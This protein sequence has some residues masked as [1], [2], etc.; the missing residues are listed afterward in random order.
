VND[1][2]SP[3]PAPEPAAQVAPVAPVAHDT[4]TSNKLRRA[5]SRVTLVMLFAVVLY[6]G[7]AVFSGVRALGDRLAGF[8][9]WTFGAALLLAFGNYII[10]FGKWQYYLAVLDIR[11][12]PVGDSFLTFLSGFILSVTPGKLGEVFKSYVLYETHG[13]PAQRTAPIV[14]AD[15]LT[16]LIGVI[17]LIAI[18]S[19]RFKGGLL[20]AGLGSA[21]VATIFV[22]VFSRR[23]SMWTIALV[24]S[25]GGP[26]KWIAP[27]LREAYDSLQAL[28]KP[29]RLVLPTLLSIA[30]WFLECLAL[31]IILHGFGQ[32][33]GPLGASF[34]YATSTLAGIFSPGGLLLTE[35]VMRTLMREVGDVDPSG[36]TGA[37]LLVRFATLWFAVVVGFVA[38]TILR[39]RYP[40]LFKT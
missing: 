10:R 40:T 39:R 28:T 26:G 29:S 20:W 3:A 1:T 36:A 22:F 9:W 8:A 14:I 19:T 34:F 21:L 25:M 11:G 5:V 13:I 37:M 17:V 6:F 33:V 18:G 7:F 30:A 12:I 4:A 35:T 31:W 15:R 23:L 16:D 32:M 24:E 27:K 2:A 38:L